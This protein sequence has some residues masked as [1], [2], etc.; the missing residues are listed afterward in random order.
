MR[1]ELDFESDKKDIINAERLELD[2][3]SNQR[4]VREAIPEYRR[5]LRV[6]HLLYEVK[7]DKLG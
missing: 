2:Y 5:S 3:S 1:S 4:P 7:D 6:G